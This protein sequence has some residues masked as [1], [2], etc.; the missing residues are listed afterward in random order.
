MFDA[1]KTPKKH[2][3][4]KGA[5]RAESK[6]TKHVKGTNFE[7]VVKGAKRTATVQQKG[8]QHVRTGKLT[9]KTTGKWQ[10]K[11]Q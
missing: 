7:R 3:A 4:S 10:K 1:I 11:R 6:D 2:P 8:V 5:K 9:G